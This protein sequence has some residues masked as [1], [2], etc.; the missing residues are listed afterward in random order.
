M[1]VNGMKNRLYFIFA[2]CLF[3]TVP[4]GHFHCLLYLSCWWYLALSAI[5]GCVKVCRLKFYGKTDKEKQEEISQM[6]IR[7]YVNISHELRTPLTLIV[8]PLQELL[9]RISGHWEHEQ[10][11]YIQRNTNR[12]LHLVNQL[13]DYRRAELGIFELR[14]VSAN[15][16]KRVLNSFMNY[17][18]LSK[19]KI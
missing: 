4:G 6:K 13:M 3:G 5:S 8:A 1:T 16:Y 17:E 11:L 2:S 15:A 18:S 14:L 7:F 9:S 19:K 12:L 10:L